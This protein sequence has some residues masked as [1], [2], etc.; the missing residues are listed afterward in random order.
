LALLAGYAGLLTGKPEAAASKSMLAEK[1]ELH[2]YCEAACK[3]ARL[4][5]NLDTF[6]GNYTEGSTLLSQN[7]RHAF[8]DR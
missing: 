7:R 3:T 4:A 2:Q 1:T 5:Q 8:I 6:G